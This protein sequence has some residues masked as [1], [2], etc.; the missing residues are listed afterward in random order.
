MKH[1]ILSRAFYGWLAYVRHLKTIRLHLAGLINQ[2]EECDTEVES[3]QLQDGT[4]SKLTSEIWTK[5]LD[6][7]KSSK[8][9][10]KTHQKLF[11]SYIYNGGVDNDIRKS[12]WPFLLSHHTL[13]MDEIDRRVVDSK[14][15]EYYKGLVNQWKP[16]EEYV[17]L[18]ENEAKL[19]Y[20]TSTA[21]PSNSIKQPT[22]PRNAIGFS[23][24]PIGPSAQSF[25][26]RSKISA[27]LGNKT[28]S[29]VHSDLILLRKDSALNND[30]F[31]EDADLSIENEVSLLHHNTLEIK[32]GSILR[33]FQKNNLNETEAVDEL[34]TGQLPDKL[35]ERIVQDEELNDTIKT[36]PSR[37]SSTCSFISFDS[38]GIA[39]SGVSSLSQ[40]PDFK[41]KSLSDKELI[42]SFAINMHRIDKDVTRCDRNYFYFT[43]QQNLTKIRNIMYT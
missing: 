2:N 30:V 37:R 24:T 3:E 11:Y 1:Q 5:W 41:R 36:V 28:K 32:N 10:L 9:S 20:L 7:E 33:C 12:V 16:F 27:M 19:Q 35:N 29:L 31:I 6:D 4:D 8:V 25:S 39:E 43:S 15:T 26:F 21:K 13:E 14:T 40:L 17:R 34:T 42:E 38:D 18:K 23:M 22:S